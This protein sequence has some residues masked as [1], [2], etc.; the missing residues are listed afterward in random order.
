MQ[1]CSAMLRTRLKSPSLRPELR[2]CL[3]RSRHIPRTLTYF[4][5]RTTLH[6][7]YTTPNLRLDLVGVHPPH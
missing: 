5:R 6:P 4:C 7:D 2:G 3:S 1:R